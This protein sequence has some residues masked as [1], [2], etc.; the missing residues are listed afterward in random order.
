MA[1]ANTD[2]AAVDVM[3]RHFKLLTW[4]SIPETKPLNG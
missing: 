3:G 4:H 2:E 1:K